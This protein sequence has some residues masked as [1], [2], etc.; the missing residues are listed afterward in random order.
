MAS[1]SQQPYAQLYRRH[2]ESV[3]R[4]MFLLSGS[5]TSAEDFTQEAFIKAVGRL[6]HLRN[7]SAFGAYWR[8]T[9]VNLYRMDFRHRRAQRR[10]LAS[11]DSPLE[12]ARDGELVE[13]DALRTALMGLS[14]RQRTAIVLRYY[15]GM[16]DQEIADTLDCA[17]GTVRSLLSR[18]LA[19]L[20]PLIEEET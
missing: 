10:I 11:V 20:R 18:G 19:S 7:P 4:T 12:H 13:A 6:A 8:K 15:A 16:T 3:Q 9:A 1:A 2:F 17:V 14:L 5:A